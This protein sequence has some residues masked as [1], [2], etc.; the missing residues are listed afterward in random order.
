MVK[1]K[2]EPSPAAHAPPAHLPPAG[3]LV[4]SPHT[5]KFHP[6][7]LKV[8]IWFDDK[9]KATAFEQYFKR[10]SGHAFARRHFW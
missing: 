2:F 4:Q 10:S 9:E 7:K 5:S 6:W 1:R 3:G 8:S